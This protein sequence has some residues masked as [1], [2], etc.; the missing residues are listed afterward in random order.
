MWDSDLYRISLTS[1]DLPLPDTPV[2]QVMTPSGNLTVMFFKLFARAL[3]TVSQPAGLR[4]LA[5]MGT[6]RR[7]ERYWPVSEFGLSMISC[8]V[9]AATIRPPLIP[10]PGPT[11][12]M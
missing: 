4:R 2:T 1:D 3:R 10:A 5:G 12:T 9:P 7:P 6:D 11:S 8:G